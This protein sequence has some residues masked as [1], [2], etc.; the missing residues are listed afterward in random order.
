MYAS[1]ETDVDYFDDFRDISSNDKRL[2]RIGAKTFAQTGTYITINLYKKHKEGTFMYRQEI[3]LST[4]ELESLADI[5]IKIK[6]LNEKNCDVTEKLRK[7]RN[8][9]KKSSCSEKKCES[10][11]EYN[12]RVVKPYKL[13]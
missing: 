5:Y 2:V 9:S 1:L 10:E 3:T 12:C 13:V 8:K 6:R 4:G 11:S 7:K